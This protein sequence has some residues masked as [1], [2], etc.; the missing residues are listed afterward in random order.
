ML[1]KINLIVIIRVE[2][3][4][5]DA[6]VERP[7]AHLHLWTHPKHNYLWATSDEKNL[8]FIRKYFLQLKVQRRKHRK[9]GRRG[10]FTPMSPGGELKNG[11]V[12][13]IRN[14]PQEARTL[15]S[16]SGSSAWGSCPG[17]MSSW[18]I[19]LWRPAGLC[20]IETPLLNVAHKIS[21]VPGPKTEAAI[22][23]EPRSDPSADLG[24]SPGEAGDNLNLLSG[25]RHWQQK[26]WGAHS[27]TLTLVLAG[28]ICNPPSSL[29]AFSFGTQPQLH[30]RNSTHQYWNISGQTTRQGGT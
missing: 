3:L 23:K 8:E 28:A 14:S 26:L 29:L 9:M 4:G 12:I 15:S 17:K 11:R 19:W 18:N 30:P 2:E 25:H 27:A 7:W 13:T 24:E 20:E 5:Q 16:I 6:G 1:W 22:W 10:E 21:H